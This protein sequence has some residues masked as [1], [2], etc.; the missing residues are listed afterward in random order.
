MRSPCESYATNAHCHLKCTSATNT[1]HF[2]VADIAIAVFLVSTRC[3]L[4]YAQDPHS[5]HK[6][7]Q[8][9][10]RYTATS[11]R[12]FAS[13]D[14]H[15]GPSSPPASAAPTSVDRDC[16]SRNAPRSCPSAPTS[17]DRNSY[18]ASAL[19]SFPSASAAPT[20]TERND[21]ALNETRSF[22]PAPVAP[23]MLIETPLL[24]TYSPRYLEHLL[25]R[26]LPVDPTPLVIFFAF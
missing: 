19:Q 16:V 17:V 2:W 21:S 22:R 5:R 24:R 26:H 4:I 10:S 3:N 13:S 11:R 23:N 25:L 8:A 7:Q 14:L 12:L 1:N 20:P 15:R 6:S 18:A 9:V